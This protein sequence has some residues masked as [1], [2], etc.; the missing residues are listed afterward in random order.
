MTRRQNNQSVKI[1]Y[2]SR[3]CKHGLNL[4]TAVGVSFVLKSE[5]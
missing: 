3:L 5:F 4:H 1:K 2:P